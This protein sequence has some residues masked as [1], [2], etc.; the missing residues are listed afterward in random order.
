M[1]KRTYLTITPDN[2]KD[3]L[4]A[5]GRLTDGNY[6][7][8][9]DRSE[10]L[11]FA[12]P[13][14][15]LEKV[16]PW[17]P[18]NTV[19]QLNQTIADNL[20]PAEEFAQVLKDAGFILPNNSLPEMDGKRHR[21][22]TEGDKAGA[23]SGVYQGFLDGRPAGWYQDHRASE[24][25]VNWTS[26]GSH[27]YD[28]AEAMK[29][30]ALAAQK[31][32]DREI[33]SQLEF[34]QMGKTLSRQ[35]SKMPPALETHAYL[36]RKGVP[37]ADGVRL[38]KY[39]N[40]VIPL[41]NSDGKLRT[42]Q[43]I[44]PD[45]TKNLKKGAEKTGNFF[46]VGGELS[47]QRPVLYAEGYATAA[48]LHLATGMP[49]VMTVDAGNLV[50]VSRNLKERYPDSHHIILG[51]DDFTKTNNRGEQ[52][53]KG[54]KKAQEAAAAINGIYIIPSFT[55]SERAQAFAGTASF[56]DFNDIHVA[57]GLD[58]V[59]EQLAPIFDE[60]IP[61]WRQ[62][63]METHSMPD[64]D[65]WQDDPAV[66]FPDITDYP[67]FGDDFQEAFAPPQDMP[68]ST[69]PPVQ[70]Q[71]SLEPSPKIAPPEASVPPLTP[72]AEAT[73]PF[74][75]DNQASHKVP[76][77][78][79]LTVEPAAPEAIGTSPTD[80]ASLSAAETPTVA[81][82]PTDNPD[83][84]N[85]HQA[86]A[87][88]AQT[89]PLV[90]PPTPDATA[91]A[92]L[93]DA[94]IPPVTELPLK[95][96]SSQEEQPQPAVAEADTTP[97]QEN[98]FSFTFGRLPGD[99][100]PEGPEVAR[101]NLDELLQGLTSRQEDRTWV[102]ALDGED[103][104]RDYGDR[105]VM[106]SPQAS[107][108]DRMILAAL[109]SAKA[110]QRGAVE[111]TGSPE[112]IQRTLT[113][114]ADHNIKVHL[115]NPHQREQFE[116]L[117]QARAA[118]AM[119]KNGI[120]I[121]TPGQEAAP[122]PAADTPPAAPDAAQTAPRN[123][124]AIQVPPKATEPT[125]PE[126]TVFEKETLRTGLTGKLLESG[127]APYQFDKANTESFYVQLRT[128]AGNKTYWGVELEQALKD[129]GQKQGDIV[130][131]QYLGKQPVTINV[132]LTNEDG[133]VTG[134]ERQEKHRNHW[135]LTPAQ[136]NRLLVADRHHV[137]PAEL[138]AY[139]G[140]AFWQLQQQIIKAAALSLSVPDPRGHGLLYTGPDGE[141]QKPPQSP[142]ENAVVPA[143]SKA[144]GS[145][146]M[147][148]AGAEGEL[149][150][151]LVKSHGDYLQ[152]VMRHE[153]ELR[154]V[155]ARVCTGANGNTWLAVNTVSD[156]G[157]LSLIGHGSAVNVVKNGEAL[158]DTFAFQLKGKD[159]PKFAASLVSPEKIPPALHSKLGFDKPWTPPKAPEPE[160]A[161]RAQ[162]KPA[163][164][165]QP[166]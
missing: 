5:A 133:V 99:V 132:P 110:N 19:S 152:G 97:V 8:E 103:A 59:R 74:S 91:E 131:L 12:K 40:L 67:D 20:T 107:E 102:Y 45:G 73:L 119:A 118:E 1:Q 98:G 143:L 165:P 146:V 101:I 38:D 11:W 123:D 78:S 82:S 117:L 52:D 126:M 115:K 157:A 116:A 85:V 100:S 46:V 141:G 23:T 64:N 149:L 29:Q 122:V 140:N 94:G 89:P 15:D 95:N 148:A 77:E 76:D 22:A 66:P 2:K 92:Q 43:Y 155:L 93:A 35:W 51:E 111:V 36:S 153:G 108:N 160:Q 63:F 72:E 41:R 4:R 58:A 86:D 159:A 124:A 18:E 137:A 150:T 21:V 136:D 49:V 96:V 28:P 26:T 10:K 127:R 33:Q 60:L 25:K 84:Q 142:P 139:D 106:A 156:S 134:Y 75:P 68:E 62:P 24:G 125:A 88:N 34:A 55:E 162:V 87:V 27:T 128:K 121:S 7:L 154:H 42:L 47:P 81:N 3:A 144:A 44:K 161:P 16:K 104:F 105:I 37:A 109:L 9:Y 6:A 14:A 129:S 90:S 147:H 80:T 113:L 69:S 13:D 17:L 151:H 61:D 164:Q 112:F 158:R 65:I 114:I 120:N 50:T 53:N 56:S 83:L 145:V 166:M 130:K 48:S 30:R 135:S 163:N 54:A 32:W 31:R 79:V 57:N 70:V 71:E 138:S 39:D